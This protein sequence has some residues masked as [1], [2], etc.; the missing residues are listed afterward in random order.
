MGAF[1]SD[2]E[3]DFIKDSP[4][5]PKK[6][7]TKKLKNFQDDSDDDAFG[8][9]TKKPFPKRPKPQLKRLPRK[10]HPLTMIPKMRSLKRPKKPRLPPRRPIK[11]FQILAAVRNSI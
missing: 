8:L 7:A 11:T 1:E 9:A 4:S 3:D 2:D 10:N 6:K 5:P